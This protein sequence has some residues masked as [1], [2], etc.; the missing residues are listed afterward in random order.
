MIDVLSRIRGGRRSSGWLPVVMLFVAMAVWGVSAQD[1]TLPGN[2][3]SLKFAVISDVHAEGDQKEYAVARQMAAVHA[4]FPFD[5]VI[6]AGD[7]MNESQSPRDFLDKFEKPF[8]PL[9]DA[10]VQFYATLG[11]HDSPSQRFYKPWNMGGDRYYTF[12]RHNV[13]FFLL[14]SNVLDPPQLAWIDD[15]LKNARDDWKICFLH[16][17]PY[18]DGKTHGSQMGVR[19]ALEPMF[20]KYGVN[21]VFTGHEHI[22]ERITPQKGISWFVTGGGGPVRK[23]DTKPGAMTAAYFDQDQTFMIVEVQGDDLFFQAISRE[24]KSVDSGIIHRRPTT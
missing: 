5:M 13:R 4:K 22:Y 6:T 12:A 3:D 11:N 16:H 1:V 17:P 2:P 20:V 23:G 24:G 14:D 19:A 15:A 21:V 8:G 10:G 7:N 18:S 9:L